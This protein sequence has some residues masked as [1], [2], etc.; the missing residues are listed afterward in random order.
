MPDV[1]SAVAE[2][3]LPKHSRVCRPPE[4]DGLREKP[5][6]ASFRALRLELRR[7]GYYRRDSARIMAQLVWHCGLT[8][9]GIALFIA[10]PMW[11]ARLAA[12]FLFGAGLLGIST[13]THTSSHYSTFRSRRLNEVMT[14]FGYPVVL[15][16]SASYWWQKHVVVHHK[17]P[18]LIGLDDD[19]DLMPFFAVTDQERQSA[20]GWRRVYY[21]LQWLLFPVA[22]SLNAFN[23]QWY[24]WRHLTAKLRNPAERQILH[25]ADLACLCVHHALW[26]G[27]PLLFFSP[28]SVLLFHVYKNVI[29]GYALFIAFAPA[30][31][32]A[33]AACA[34]AD[35]QDIDFVLKQTATTVN[36][37]TGWFGR[38]ACSGVEYQIEHHLFCGISHTRYPEVSRLLEEFCRHHGYPYK[39]LGWAEAVWKSLLVF[40]QPKHVEDEL[41]L[42][43]TLAENN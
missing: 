14:F 26:I 32:P 42:V 3:E 41:R 17:N 15:G 40:Y 7:R 11:W 39:T 10:F 31:F 20:R 4:T 35:Q 19:L 1:S 27:L 34:E 25:W 22:I 21:S 6:L 29:V 37:R 28:A 9:L 13:N 2:L 30:H 5:Y 24:A 23:V 18:N 16:M 36:F 38:L 8:A 12:T 43:S 33:E